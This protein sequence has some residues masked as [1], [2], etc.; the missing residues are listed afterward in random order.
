M[1]R[2]TVIKIVVAVLLFDAITLPFIIMYV[3]RQT[4][5]QEGDAGRSQVPAETYQPLFP[6]PDFTFTSQAEKPFGKADL[7]GKVWVVDVFFTTCAGP[8]PVMSRA[9]SDLAKQ[10]DP[11]TGPRFVSITVD[12]TYDTPA[13]LTAYAQRYEA[14]LSEWT[15]LTGDNAKLQEFGA[16][17]LKLG[18]VDSPLMHSEK[19]VLADQQGMICGYF[20]GTDQAD[21]AR[22]K[23]AIDTLLKR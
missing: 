23:T 8:C 20:T 13:V 9:M 19:F 6:V 12:P 15:F 16:V 5:P 14:D 4:G 22:L 21:V 10:Y 1:P 2:K 17:G 3:L 7:L 11:A 18:S